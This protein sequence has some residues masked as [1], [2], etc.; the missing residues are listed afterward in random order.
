[1]TNE[2]ET[3]QKLKTE[4]YH[5]EHNDGHGYQH[6]STIF[7]HLMMLAFLVDQIQQLAYREF[8]AALKRCRRRIRLWERMRSAFFE[9]F[10]ESW[11]I[12]FQTITDSPRIW[13]NVQSPPQVTEV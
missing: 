2:N 10:V 11:D 6:L 12:L 1:M 5:F 4:R 3:F 13:L 8:Q 7:A 9:F